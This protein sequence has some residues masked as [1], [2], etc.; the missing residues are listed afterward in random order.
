MGGA[1]IL[2]DF[3]EIFIFFEIFKFPLHSLTK[4][5]QFYLFSNIGGGFNFSTIWG[6]GVSVHTVLAN[7]NGV[8]QNRISQ[9]YSPRLALPF[10]SFRF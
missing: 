7:R 6:G 2:I 1:R 9:K 4:V 8:P 10:R 3:L 5:G